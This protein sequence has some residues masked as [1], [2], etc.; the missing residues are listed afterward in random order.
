[1]RTNTD[2]TVYN[3]Y[4][5][6]TTRSELYQRTIIPSV[7]IQGPYGSNVIQQGGWVRQNTATISIPYTRGKFYLKPSAWKALGSKTGF[8]TLWIGDVI[9][10]GKVTDELHPLIPTVIGPPI[11]PAVPAFTLTDLRSKYLESCWVVTLVDVMDNGSPR[12]WHWK[13]SAA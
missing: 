5:D 4:I 11:I 10:Q 3:K 2:I 9:V 13:V 12:M 8:W 7:V 1:M 6:P